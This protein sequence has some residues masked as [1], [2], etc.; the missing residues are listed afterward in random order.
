MNMSDTKNA[1]DRAFMNASIIAAQLNETLKRDTHYHCQYQDLLPNNN[2]NRND[3]GNKGCHSYCPSHY[4][5]VPDNDSESGEA[6]ISSLNKFLLS[7]V[8]GRCIH[9]HT[10]TYIYIYIYTCHYHYY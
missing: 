3:N 1:F 5:S 9:T 2:N 7:E 6:F 8:K 10:H 4:G